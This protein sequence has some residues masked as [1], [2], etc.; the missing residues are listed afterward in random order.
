M[1]YPCNIIKD[2]L[3]LYVDSVCSEESK[4]I[5]KQHLAECPDCKAYYISMT[6]TNTILSSPVNQERERQKAQSFLAVRKRLRFKLLLAA[7]ISAVILIAV[8]FLTV[9][10]L[11]NY[12]KIVTYDDDISVAMVDGSLVG[13]LIGSHQQGVYIKRV[14]VTTDEYE[15]S[16]LFFCVYDTKLDELITSKEVFS[17]FILCPAN[18]SAD[19]IDFVFYYTGDDTDIE[20]MSYNELQSV[21]DKSVLLWSK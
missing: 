14:N 6:E 1:K 3:P 12:E 15:L 19:E 17:E 10:I 7:M 20:K 8:V 9:A 13:R 16:C 11:G 2:L 18:K 5:I 4:E 21:I